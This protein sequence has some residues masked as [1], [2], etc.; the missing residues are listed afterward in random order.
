MLLVLILGPMSVVLTVFYTK[1]SAI[2]QN[3][4]ADAAVVSA[5]QAGEKLDIL[6]H[7][8]DLFSMQVLMEK[9]IQQALETMGTNSGKIDQSAKAKAKLKEMMGPYKEMLGI[10]LIARDQDTETQMPLLTKVMKEKRESILQS[11][12]EGAGK[13]VFLGIDNSIASDD[14][15]KK[16]KV[17]VFGRPLKRISTSEDYGVLLFEIK[18]DAINETLAKLNNGGRGTA[19]LIGRDN[20][21]KASSD[22]TLLGSDSPVSVWNKDEGHWQENVNGVPSMVIHTSSGITGWQ[23]ATVVPIGDVMKDIENLRSW[24]GIM[25]LAAAVL[26]ILLSYIAA[27]RMIRPIERLRRVMMQGESGDLTAHASM[28]GKNELAELC[29]SFNQMMG[30]IRGL[31][32]QTRSAAEE[33]WRASDQL[34]SSSERVSSHSREIAAATDEI[35]N[36]TEQQAEALEQGTSL[37]AEMEQK[38]KLMMDNATRL[39]NVS[40]QVQE[41][42]TQG[43]RHMEKLLEENRDA[44]RMM[45][46]VSEKVG[47][48]LHRL[49]SIEN[50][51]AMLQGMSKQT[52]ILSLNAAIESNRAGAAGKGFM[53]V[54][55]EIRHLAKGTADSVREV[56]ALVDSIRTD[57]DGAQSAL[58]GAMPVL[59]EQLGSAAD[60]DRL[61]KDVDDGMQEAGAQLSTWIESIGQLEKAQDDLLGAISNVAAV[62]QQTSATARM[63]AS[64]ASDQNELTGEQVQWSQQLDRLSTELRTSMEQFHI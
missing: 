48:L 4:L 13:T 36:G 41:R 42:C 58:T 49:G 39:T 20:R 56:A 33:V 51:L 54:A 30:R 12:K 7:Q 25:V 21:I 2:M 38:M 3:K 10:Y 26:V 16:Q 24:V 32:L 62:S 37:V 47:G 9:D 1:A 23:L 43:S 17:L 6:L 22:E 57:M 19:L 61:F 28:K 63:V 34:A 55:E 8:Y 50:V 46:D 40:L 35:A 14:F 44:G 59:E 60:A 15:L 29:V 31:F 18:P 45:A 64:S 52:N 5:E 11:V 27:A 53:V